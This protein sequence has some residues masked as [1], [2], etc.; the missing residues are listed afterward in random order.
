MLSLLEPISRVQLTFPPPLYPTCLNASPAV[1]QDG[2]HAFL[3]AMVL[4]CVAVGVCLGAGMAVLCHKQE[5]MNMP[6]LKDMVEV[7][8]VA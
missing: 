5:F 2:N 6:W 1:V 4:M 7:R 8:R 3:M